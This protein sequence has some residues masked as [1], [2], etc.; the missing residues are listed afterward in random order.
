MEFIIEKATKHQI[1]IVINLLKEL[2]LEL[3]DEAESIRF[4]DKEFIVKILNSGKTEIHLA[5]IDEQEVVGILTLTECQSIYA[6][7]SYGLID[8][9]FIKPEFRSR[10]IGKALIQKI[11]IIGKQRNWKRIDVTAPVE[12]KWKRTVDFYRKCG[13]K[14]TGPKLKFVL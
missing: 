8:E 6:G 4:L 1:S 11:I 2:Y 12:D 3:G 14:F 9:M 5:K 10:N 7:G 13:F